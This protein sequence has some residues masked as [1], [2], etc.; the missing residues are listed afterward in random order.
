MKMIKDF[1]GFISEQLGQAPS[2]NKAGKPYVQNSEIDERFLTAAREGDIESCRF[3]LDQG[4]NI[5][6]QDDYGGETALYLAVERSYIDIVRLLI[7]RGADP[8]LS[9]WEFVGTPLSL[10]VGMEN[11]DITEMLLGSGRCNEK[12]LNGAS[13]AAFVQ[14][15]RD[16]LKT[17][18]IFSFKKGFDPIGFFTGD[19]DVLFKFFDGDV[20]W[21]P[22]VLKAKLQRMRRGKSAFGM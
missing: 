1:S 4:A 14:G 3:L 7:E 15:N 16:L 8:N 18:M 17:L 11:D 9:E 22:E 20:D 12:T 10:A 19:L 5:D 21:M 2:R 6:A 13:E